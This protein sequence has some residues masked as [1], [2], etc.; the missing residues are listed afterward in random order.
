MKHFLQLT[1]FEVNRFFKMFMAIV[2][3]TFFIQITGTA[4]SAYN[5]MRQVNK[6]VKSGASQ[7]DIL[8]QVSSFGLLDIVYTIYFSLP[9]F[10]GVTAL[11]FY[12]F[13][14]WYRDWFAKS[15]FIYRLLTLPTSRMNVYFAKLT[16]IMLMTLGLTAFQLILLAIENKVV[17]FIVPKVYRTDLSIAQVIMHSE[18]LG[19]ILP[20]S[21]LEFVL[22]YA[23]GLIFT[24]VIFTAIL[25]ERSYKLIGAI[26]G[27]IYVAVMSG[28]MIAPFIIF[29]IVIGAEY[30]YPME[31]FYLMIAVSLVIM[32]G[33]LFISRH[34]MNKKVTV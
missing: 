9:I 30:L 16:T 31:F 1:N 25:F 8:D 13:F 17:H 29:Y 32:I 27:A 10:V 4:L 15:T 6:L 28:I 18:Y 22:Y 12:T 3:L 34:L 33:S 7:Q 23:L 24:I 2:V 20:T 21:L 26:I 14:I 19:A 5:Y 11:L